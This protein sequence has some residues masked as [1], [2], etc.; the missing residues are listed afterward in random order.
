MRTTQHYLPVPCMGLAMRWETI[1]EEFK[2]GIDN[3]DTR[4]LK[5]Y[6]LVVG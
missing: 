3:E 2:A 6:L 1:Q 5:E 4:R